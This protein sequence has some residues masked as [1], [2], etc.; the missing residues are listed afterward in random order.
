VGENGGE[1]NRDSLEKKRKNNPG[2]RKRG[3]KKHMTQEAE[4]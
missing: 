4:Q 1:L 3:E 2:K